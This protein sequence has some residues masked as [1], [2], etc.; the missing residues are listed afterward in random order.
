MTSGSAAAAAGG[1]LAPVII[2]AVIPSIPAVSPNPRMLFRV[3]Y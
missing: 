3:E 1:Y 2:L